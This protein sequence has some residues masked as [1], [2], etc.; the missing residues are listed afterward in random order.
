[1]VLVLDPKKHIRHREKS[2]VI[3]RLLHKAVNV[4]QPSRRR[5]ESAVVTDRR[6]DKTQNILRILRGILS[7]ITPEKFDAAGDG[8]EGN[9]EE[10]LRGTIS[11]IFKMAL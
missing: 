1:M 2:T 4:Y 7:K 5:H 6:K 11:L 8:S 10:R 3:F 9:A